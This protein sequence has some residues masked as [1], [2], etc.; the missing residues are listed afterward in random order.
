MGLLRRTTAYLDKKGVDKARLDAEVL[1]AHSLNLT[2]VELYL[3]FDRPLLPAELDA[4]RELV[5]R[6]AALEPVA[7]ITGVK[8]F[9]SMELTVDPR[10]LIP[11]PE[12]ELAVD[13]AIRL[14][15]G[16]QPA[17]GD[18]PFRALD[19]GTGSG[20]IALALARELPE[21]EIWAT[22][23]SGP[24]LEVA[25]ANAGRHGLSSRVKFSQG[26][27]FEPVRE[28]K[29]YFNLI[30]ANLP[31][32]PRPVLTNMAPDIREYEPMLALDGGEDGLNLI[33][34]AI[35]EA[36]NFLKPGG[37]L[38]L[39]IWPAQADWIIEAG[40]RRG[41]SRNNLIRD[42]AGYALIVTLIRDETPG[43]QGS[44]G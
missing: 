35:E 10:V 7:Y 19:L 18:D 25:R 44:H 14:A 34:R 42:H 39:E 9:Y 29:D 2:R 26:D 24:A 28:M 4:F 1:L 8:E 3:S 20:A 12:T 33:R 13:E 43:E 17:V 21:A 15:G 36:N 41:Y 40:K 11:R 23:L 6:R 27:L 32:V 22:D 31:Y 16:K 38:V 30:I 37:A 5:R